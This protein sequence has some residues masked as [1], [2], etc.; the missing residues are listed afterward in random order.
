MVDVIWSD[1]T[2]KLNE[3]GPLR[4]LRAEW[5]KEAPRFVLLRYTLHGKEIPN[6]IRMDLDKQVILDSV[7]DEQLDARLFFATRVDLA[8]DNGRPSEHHHALHS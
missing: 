1:L 2:G 5:W 3:I 8:S 4:F 6:G 7:G